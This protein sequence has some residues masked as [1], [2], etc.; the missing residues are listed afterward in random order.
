MNLNTLRKE[1]LL[2][3]LSPEGLDRAELIANLQD[4]LMALDDSNFEFICDTLMKSIFMRDPDLLIRFVDN[5]FLCCKYREFYVGKYAF[6]LFSLNQTIE[7]AIKIK[8]SVNS[9]AQTKDSIDHKVF[10]FKYLLETD[11]TCRL[12]A[13]KELNITK[14]KNEQNTIPLKPL[15]WI[16]NLNQK[17]DHKGRD[18]KEPGNIS[19]IHQKPSQPKT[20]NQKPPQIKTTVNGNDSTGNDFKTANLSSA[21]F[22]FQNDTFFNDFIMKSVN[23]LTLFQDRIFTITQSV[24]KQPWR[25]FCI[26]K[27]IEIFNN[28][29]KYYK[30]IDDFFNNSITIEIN[31]MNVFAYFVPLIKIFSPSRYQNLYDDMKKRTRYSRLPFSFNEFFLN[32]EES[33]RNNWRDHGEL[34]ENCGFQKGTSLYAIRHD[35]VDFFI[36]RRKTRKKDIDL[37]N[38]ENEEIIDYNMRVKGNIFIR[39]PQLKNRCTLLQ[40]AAYYGSEKCFAFLLENG[41]DPKLEDDI[42]LNV[43]QFAVIGGSNTII[44][45]LQKLGYDFDIGSISLVVESYRFTLFQW[46]L[47]TMKVNLEESYFQTGTII[48]R[49]AS[50][51][52]TLILL[53]CI[54]NGVNVNVFDN[55]NLTPLYYAAANCSIDAINILLAHKDI[56]WELGDK[57]KDSPLHGSTRGDDCDTF[58]ALMN[59]KDANVNVRDFRNKS[60]LNY[61]VADGKYDLVRMI[62]TKYKD[63]LD[64]DEV[65]KEGENLPFIASFTGFINTF[66]IICNCERIDLNRPRYDG[67]YLIHLLVSSNKIEFVRIFLNQERADPN[68]KLSD[69]TTALHI[70]AKKGFAEIVKLFVNN[71]KT[72]VNIKDSYGM[73]PLLLALKHINT[74]TVKVLI[75][76][77]RID[78]EYTVVL[79]FY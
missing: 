65:D 67:Y 21:A 35:D 40:L 24:T 36:K 27:C 42:G 7:N 41:A 9:G 5:V 3:Y 10:T 33:D 58:I 47:S 30:Y 54:A 61:C 16:E 52:N 46:I 28:N 66:T 43:M 77:D 32:F 4:I 1:D 34:I 25:L 76:C 73:T 45:T 13:N 71:Q 60:A 29:S 78:K 37:N 56:I 12:Y 70:A 55:L 31:Q 63:V 69:G 59:H 74:D 62:L 49:A 72:D 22:E 38:V 19:I 68:V 57:F 18:E 75:T 39:Y 14:R 64:Y 48:H 50:S 44:L 51:N 6:L 17:G 8:N 11:Q 2:D 20:E 79:F 23:I 26:Y 15:M 53:F